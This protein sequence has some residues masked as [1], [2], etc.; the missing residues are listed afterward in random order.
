M[1]SDKSGPFYD[2]LKYIFL[3]TAPLRGLFQLFRSNLPV[4]KVLLILD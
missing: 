3:H 4:N 2:Y 1:S